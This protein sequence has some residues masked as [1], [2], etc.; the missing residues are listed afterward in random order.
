MSGEVVITSAVRTPI[1][2]YCGSLREVPAHELGALVLKEAA[3]RSGLE[4]GLIEDVVMGQSYQNGESVNL[5]RMS[6]L[7]AGWPVEI[8]GV[9][10]DRRCLS[11]LDA[12]C[13]AAM[14]IMSGCAEVVA[15]GGVESM[16]RAELYVPGEFVKWGLGGLSDPKWGFMPKGHGALPMWGIPFFDR[17]QRA[18]VMS[19]PVDR[20]GELNSMMTWAEAAAREEGISREAADCWALR[21][22][23]RAVAAT[24][25]GRFAEET[26][27][28]SLPP[29]KGEAGL[30]AQDETPRA[31]VSL[32]RLAKLPAVYAGGIC[33]AGNSS[34]ENDGAA[35]VVLMST[36]KAAR[37]GLEPLGR[38]LGFAVAAADPRLTYPAVPAAVNK[39]L[40]RA[41]LTLADMDLIEVQEAFAA[42]LLADAKLMG[43]GQERME[44][45]LNVNGSGI[46]LGH[47][48]AAT[49]VMRLTT[50]LH[51]MR[52]R[53]SR[54]GLE[55]I[56][57]GG[58]QGIA[59]VVAR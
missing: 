39:A 4:P 47:P 57:G 18:R 3:R 24:R 11:G 1:G 42:Q 28:V 32:A 43:L 27:A 44:E 49:G 35:A 34:T 38:L 13:F 8:P 7:A 25:E 40:A 58:G 31:D 14:E 59:A 15:A 36:E 12:V 19:Q 33:T 22:H 53:G 10:L 2:K 20:F 56:C 16:S 21:S 17:I 52:R 29:K 55:A 54:Y 48:I 26:V 51:E 6:L 50:L 9:T 30:F 41:G 37:L 45:K 46:S 5:A 23:E